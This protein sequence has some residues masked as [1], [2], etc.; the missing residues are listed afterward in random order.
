[1]NALTGQQLPPSDVV[2]GEGDGSIARYSN[3]DD[4]DDYTCPISHCDRGP[5]ASNC[6]PH[7]RCIKGYCQCNLGW[8]PESGMGMARGWSGLEALTVWSGAASDGCL[9]RCDSLK[10]SEVLQV[11][12][13]FDRRLKH[14]DEDEGD[15]EGH[16]GLETDDLHLGAIQAPGA[17]AALDFVAGVADPSSVGPAT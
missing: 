11:K 1:M 9:V 8:K 16:D 6:G 12:G 13:C 7:A 15:F 5:L 14:D 2:K 17:D 3:V 4:V 10:C